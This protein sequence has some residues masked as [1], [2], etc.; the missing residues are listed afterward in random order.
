MLS[1]GW[2]LGTAL[3]ARST[4]AGGWGGSYLPVILL[5]RSWARHARSARQLLF[6]SAQAGFRAGD[7]RCPSGPLVLRGLPRLSSL[8]IPGKPSLA[9]PF[10]MAFSVCPASESWSCE[11]SVAL[12]RNCDDEF[13]S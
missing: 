9:V 11:E 12:P 5:S 7:G 8:E 2:L 3:A 1:P 13:L 4:Q 10:E 6:S